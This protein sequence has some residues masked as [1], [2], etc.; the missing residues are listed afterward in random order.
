MRLPKNMVV[1][2][3]YSCPNTVW[4]MPYQADS[5]RTFRHSKEAEIEEQMLERYYSVTKQ[6]G[7]DA[8]K[9]GRKRR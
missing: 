6:N 7:D 2:Q 1:V 9:H 8:E 3:R 4:L 5:V